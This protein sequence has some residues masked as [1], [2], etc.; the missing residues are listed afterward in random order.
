MSTFIQLFICVL[1]ILYKEGPAFGSKSMYK[2]KQFVS[3]ILQCKS[4][5]GHTS[6]LSD[7]RGRAAATS[8]S[9]VVQ[10]EFR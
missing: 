10:S 2:N 5:M 3:F 6:N 1:Y 4:S 7:G 9:V 8:E